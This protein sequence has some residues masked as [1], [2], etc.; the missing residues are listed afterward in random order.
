MRKIFSSNG[1]NNLGPQLSHSLIWEVLLV[2]SLA[3]V[4]PAI[5][6]SLTVLFNGNFTAESS[7]C[8]IGFFLRVSSSSSAAD[9]DPT[10]D[11]NSVALLQLMTWRCWGPWIR[12]WIK[13]LICQMLARER[14]LSLWR[15]LSCA[16]S[17]GLVSGTSAAWS[18]A[19]SSGLWP[20]PPSAWFASAEPSLC[21]LPSLCSSHLLCSCDRSRQRPYHFECLW[22]F[23][24]TPPPPLQQGQGS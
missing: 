20:G 19:S 14:S 12:S 7:C 13:C 1:I 5:S 6:S 18:S 16:L 4:D 9:T 21:P 3:W 15:P 11:L 22:G 23:Y 17:F 24:M 8:Q 10:A 2:V